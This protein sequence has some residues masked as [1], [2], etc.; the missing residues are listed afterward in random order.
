MFKNRKAKFI[1]VAVAIIC[2]LSATAYFAYGKIE[3]KHQPKSLPQI[4]KEAAGKPTKKNN[5]SAV[6]AAVYSGETSNKKLSWYFIPNQSHTLPRIDPVGEKLVGQY[7]AIYHGD[8]NTKT[9]YLTFDEGYETGY[10]PKLLDSLHNQ[11]VKAAFFVTGDYLKKHPEL[12]RR[13]VAEGHIVGDHTMTHPSLPTVSAEQFKNELN[14]VNQLFENLTGSKMKYLRPPM[15]EYSERTLQMAAQLGYTH[16]FWS[17]AFKDWEPADGSP[18]YNQQKV[19]ALIHPGAL[20]LLHAENQANADM[21]ES[22]I[23]D[24]RNQGYNFGTLDQIST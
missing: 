24:L 7:H 11:G 10:T 23:T 21:L 18:E 17:V 14:G 16:V 8:V 22:L 2:L 20:V 1:P 6:S 5:P 4:T 19:M 15:G 12:V 13:M 3:V 9:V